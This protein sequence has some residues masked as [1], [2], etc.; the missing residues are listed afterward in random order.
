MMKLIHFLSFVVIA[1]MVMSCKPKATLSDEEIAE[2]KVEEKIEASPTNGSHDMY[3][4]L[5]LSNDQRAQ[6]IVIKEK[7]DVME[8]MSI[9]H[10]QSNPEALKTALEEVNAKRETELQTLFNEEQYLLYLEWISNEGN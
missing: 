7:Y 1:L 5:G 2:E 6:F 4:E 3:E 9:R 8:R 10:G